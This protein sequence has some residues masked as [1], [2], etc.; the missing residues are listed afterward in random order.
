MIS[1]RQALLG[2]AAAVAAAP[3]LITAL[4]PTTRPVSFAATWQIA[5]G[6]L[7]DVFACDNIFEVMTTVHDGDAT[8]PVPG[9]IVW[10]GRTPFRCIEIVELGDPSPRGDRSSEAREIV[11]R[12]ERLEAA[13]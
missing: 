2:G 7:E 3:F 4:G 9:A 1:R 13:L 6:L 11:A 10:R 5:F 12:I 8:L